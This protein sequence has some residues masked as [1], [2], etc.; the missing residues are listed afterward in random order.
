MLLIEDWTKVIE[1]RDPTFANGW[2]YWLQKM[3]G[4]DEEEFPFC[5]TQGAQSFNLINVKEHTIEVLI[6]ANKSGRYGQQAA[7]FKD[8]KE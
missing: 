1:I 8:E 2:K 4:F 3:P 7:I 6:K 5:I